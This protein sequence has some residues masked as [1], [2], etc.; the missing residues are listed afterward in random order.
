MSRQRERQ[1]LLDALP[2]RYRK[3]PAA[4]TVLNVVNQTDGPATLEVKDQELVVRLGTSEHRQYLGARPSGGD[5]A[6]GVAPRIAELENWFSSLGF[7]TGL[8]DPTVQNLNAAMLLEDGPVTIAP[9]A[10]H[11]LKRWT[12]EIWRLFDPAAVALVA[13][14]QR[15]SIGLAQL[16]LLTAAADFADFWGT[17][18][19]TPRRL[20]ESDEDYTARQLHELLRPRSN[21]EA[22][23]RLLEE[24]LGV[25]VIEV[26]DLEPDVFR[27]SR[28]PLRGFP[29]AGKRYNAAT[30][31]VIFGGVSPIEAYAVARANVA[32]GVR[33]VL[34]DTF[35]LTVGESPYYF[36]PSPY[37][38]G[39]PPAMKINHPDGTIGVGKIGP[40]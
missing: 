37:T 29:L 22:L 1:A 30:A 34:H 4:V 20:G 26:R 12:Q 40:P 9:A 19:S 3:E 7:A 13:A 17:V 16:N 8:P 21:N 15:I 14:G 5:P 23:A 11:G 39:S 10:F 18:T 25:P 31:E 36:G 33:V 32:A 2:R 35:D 38:I 6:I 28:T 24:D 27:C